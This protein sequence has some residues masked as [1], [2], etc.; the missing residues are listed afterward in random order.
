MKKFFVSLLA[1]AGMI[2]GFSLSSCGGGG[3][4]GTNLSG[5]MITAVCNQ[6]AYT[7]EF[8]DKLGTGYHAVISDVVG[9]DFSPIVLSISEVQGSDE[10][11]SDEPLIIKGSVASSELSRDGRHALFMI[12]TG[13]DT[14]NP[15]VTQINMIDGPR[16]TID[17]KEMKIRWTCKGTWSGIAD[18]A[19]IVDEDITVDDRPDDIIDYR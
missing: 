13:F 16:F 5:H 6:C 8:G 17:L 10:K 18:L 3:G 15:N 7:I 12:V 19:E 14:T 1:V 4:G 11:D 9:Y 2:V